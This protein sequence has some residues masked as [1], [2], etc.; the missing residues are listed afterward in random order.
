MTLLDTARPLG[1]RTWK[2]GHRDEAV[3]FVDPQRITQAM[4]QL[5]SNAVKFSAPGS[6]IALGTRIDDIGPAETCRSFLGPRRR[7]RH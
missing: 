3:A 5:C 2:I 6:A 4:L 1:E 7:H